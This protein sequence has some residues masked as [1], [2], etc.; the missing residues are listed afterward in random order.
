MWNAWE[1]REGRDTL[2]GE[3]SKLVAP[4]RGGSGSGRG[5]KRGSGSE[6]EERAE[7]VRAGPM[8]LGRHP[9]GVSLLYCR[10]AKVVRPSLYSRESD[11]LKQR[12]A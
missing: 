7:M 5:N 12:N 6:K 2:G 9:G 10:S 3:A 11:I 1:G 4:T 8:D